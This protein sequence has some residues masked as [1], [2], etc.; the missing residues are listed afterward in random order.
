MPIAFVVPW[1]A[2]RCKETLAKSQKAISMGLVQ[3]ASDMRFARAI[4]TTTPL[5]SRNTIHSV[6]FVLFFV[7]FV[8]WRGWWTKMHSLKSSYPTK[9]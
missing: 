3:G 8:R 7:L 4:P 1:E 5:R 2:I 9:T 6:C